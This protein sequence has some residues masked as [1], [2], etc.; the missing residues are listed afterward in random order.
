ML[1][2]LAACDGSSTGPRYAQT[3]VRLD[4]YVTV[5]EMGGPPPG[6]HTDYCECVPGPAT[7]VRAGRP[8]ERVECRGEYALPY[9]DGQ[10]Q[11]VTLIGRGWRATVDYTLPVD[12][13]LDI[14]VDATCVE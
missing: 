2:A 5:E 8:P 7:L 9:S 4:A 13:H 11:E 1:G 12:P 6:L 10:R 14:R 3:P